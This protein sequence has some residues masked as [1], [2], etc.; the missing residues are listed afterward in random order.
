M[1]A[2]NISSIISTGFT[3]AQ[4]RPRRSSQA[5][6]ASPARSSGGPNTANR[7]TCPGT[8]AA[9][10]SVLL[11]LFLDINANDSTKKRITYAND[12]IDGSGMTWQRAYAAAEP[13]GSSN[14]DTSKPGYT[15]SDGPHWPGASHSTW[16]ARRN[17]ALGATQPRENS[18]FWRH[19]LLMQPAPLRSRLFCVSTVS[20]V[21]TIK[22]PVPVRAEDGLDPLHVDCR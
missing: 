14:F 21:C 13:L 11:S 3:A 16:A 1:S 8:R 17:S 6:A 19:S 4:I 15:V 7:C 9:A 5:A 22:V 18:P 12:I 2:M 20:I 10:I